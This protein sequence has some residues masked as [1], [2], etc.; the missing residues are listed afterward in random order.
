MIYNCDMRAWV[1]VDLDAVLFNYS[2]LR[3]FVAPETEICCVVKA[4][5]YGHGAAKVAVELERKGV[6]FFAVSSLEEALELRE[7]GITSKIL[8]LGYTSPKC[9]DIIAKNA[10]SQCVGSCEY[11]D[12]LAEEASKLG[13]ILPI[14]IKID[15]GMGRLGFAFV[16]S[17]Y[18]S[19]EQV[20]KTCKR[21]CFIH[22]GIFTH[23][24]RADEG[25]KT[26]EYTLRQYERFCRV[27][28][29]LQAN[30][31]EFTFKHCSNSAATLGLPGLSMD[32]VRVGIALYGEFP[33]SEVSADVKLR[34]TLSFKTVISNVKTV[35]RGDE[36]GY[37]GF[38][39]A[40]KEITVATVPLGYADGFLRAYAENQTPLFVAGHPCRILGRVCMDQLMIDVTD[41]KDVKI[42]DEV[43]VFGSGSDMSLSDFA[44]LN[45]TIPYEILCTIGT[46]VRRVY[47]QGT[48]HE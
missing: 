33:S 47:L 2:A 27:I 28:D 21:N 18:E 46:R 15:V 32:M 25:K 6:S 11:A 13:V 4:D 23:F 26:K 45:K 9:A 20:L 24:P 43:T 16:H 12:A 35:R 10:I 5:A 38:F 48:N 3:S 40:D 44:A 39:V 1:E 31:I 36:I 34:R 30:G 8:I 7:A 37:G 17:E 41:I 14:H 42:G 22:E 19:I 29:I